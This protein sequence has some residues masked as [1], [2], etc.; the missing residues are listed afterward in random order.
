MG[1]PNQ[2]HP[3]EPEQEAFSSEVSHE[4]VIAYLAELPQPESIREIAHGLGLKH[5]GRRFLP[6]IIRK[7][8][9]NGDIEEVYGGRYRLAGAKQ[10]Q[11][12]AQGQATARKSA[13]ESASRSSVPN[14][15]SSKAGASNRGPSNS[16]A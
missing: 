8:K 9:K 13:T 6:R 5:H 16:G 10:T 1:R 7:F 4:Q 12:E 3:T 2:R 15:G 14:S 11:R